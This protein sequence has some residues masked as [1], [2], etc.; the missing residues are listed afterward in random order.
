[1]YRPLERGKSVTTPVAPAKQAKGVLLLG[2]T[3]TL[4][5]VLVQRP[6]GELSTDARA[7]TAAI[8]NPTSGSVTTYRRRR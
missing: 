7:T 3:C 6:W 4:K 8:E 2:G 1:M 5:T